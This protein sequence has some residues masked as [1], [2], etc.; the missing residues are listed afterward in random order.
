MNK[1]TYEATKRLVK[2]ARELINQKYAN[3]KRLARDEVFEKAM[4]IRDIT[5]VE[6]WIDEVAKEYEFELDQHN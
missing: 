4:T 1:E 2:K 3:R 5:D 6:M